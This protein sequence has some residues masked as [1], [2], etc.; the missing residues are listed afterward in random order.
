MGMSKR[1]HFF[2]V[3]KSFSC[4]HSNKGPV[5]PA[6]DVPSME[7]IGYGLGWPRAKKRSRVS[8]FATA[9]PSRID[10][11]LLARTQEATSLPQ[12]TP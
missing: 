6:L 5:E 10:G 1:F 12:L 9:G 8:L 4:K 2:A 11:A 3:A 7:A